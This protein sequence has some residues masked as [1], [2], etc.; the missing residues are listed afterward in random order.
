MTCLGRTN[1]QCLMTQPMCVEAYKARIPSQE[2]ALY[3][4]LNQRNWYLRAKAGTTTSLHLI[5]SP[6]L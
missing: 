5:P 2:A 1:R 6:M 4:S 3:F